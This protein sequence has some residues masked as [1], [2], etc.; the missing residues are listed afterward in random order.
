MTPF[1]Q[2]EDRDP[3]DQAKIIGTKNLAYYYFVT[4]KLPAYRE[5]KEADEKYNASDK[6]DRA[7]V[8]RRKRCARAEPKD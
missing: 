2:P 7:M 8:V 6:V 4:T 1:W 3:N 5:L